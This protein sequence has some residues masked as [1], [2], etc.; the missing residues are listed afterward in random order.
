M[1]SFCINGHVNIF[2]LKYQQY[3]YIKNQ[4]KLKKKNTKIAK[5]SKTVF[6]F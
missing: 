5:F 6:A 3:K 1:N 2:A 4:R